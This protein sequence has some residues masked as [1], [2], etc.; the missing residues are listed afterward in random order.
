MALVPYIATQDTYYGGQ[1][2]ATGNR[3]IYGYPERTKV[4]PTV[5]SSGEIPDRGEIVKRPALIPFTNY[6]VVGEQLIEHKPVKVLGVKRSTTQDAGCTSNWYQYSG[7]QIV[8]RAGLQTISVL[9]DLPE[10]GYPLLE[11]QAWARAKEK[12]LEV[13]LE[14]AER[15]DTIKLFTEFSERTRRRANHIAKITQRYCRGGGPLLD[16]FE[17]VWMESRY[18]W[19]QLK[20]LSEDILDVIDLLRT[21]NEYMIFRGRSKQVDQ[22]LEQPANPLAITAAWTHGYVKG[23]TEVK[24]IDTYRA[25]VTGMAKTSAQKFSHNLLALGW[26]LVPYS[27]V[28]DW[29]VNTADIVRAHWPVPEATFVSCISHKRD[30]QERYEFKVAPTACSIDSQWGYVRRTTSAYHRRPTDGIPL[31]LSV[32]VNFNIL[33]FMDLVALT[34]RRFVSLYKKLSRPKP[35][36]L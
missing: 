4:P 6:H 12:A 27:F 5:I 21:D 28:I 17:D 10:E 2:I 26:E 25:H 35:C 11:Q 33:K 23:P 7:D 32:D 29:F 22:G 24:T 13:L 3:T 20:Y 30:V 15:R 19:R 36:G 9:A 14:L 8:A 31:D 34:R 18:G 16:V 1:K